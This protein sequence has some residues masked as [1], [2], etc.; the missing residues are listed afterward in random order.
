MRSGSDFP[1][2]TEM[3]TVVMTVNTPVQVL[4][5]GQSSRKGNQLYITSYNVSYKVDIIA[6]PIIQVRKLRHG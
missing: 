6:I 4:C 3:D 5:A 1:P 2:W